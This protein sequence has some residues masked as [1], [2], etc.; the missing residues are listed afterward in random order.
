MTLL[1]SG[2]LVAAV[3]TG[4]ALL[5][6]AATVLTGGVSSTAP[7]PTIN[8]AVTTST[9][10]TTDPAS[11][12]AEGAE[13]TLTAK[14][15]PAAA[16][17]TVQFKDG[18]NPLGPP[19][20]VANGT[21]SGTTKKLTT[22]AHQL[23]AVFTP[24]NT[25]LYA[26]STSSPVAFTVTG[27]TG[28]A[29]AKDTSTALTTSPPSSAAQGTAVTLNATVAPPEAAGTVQFRDGTTPIGTPA[30][31]SNGQASTSTSTLTVGSHQLTAVF[32][33]TD[34]ATYSPSTSTVVVFQVTGSTGSTTTSIALTTSPSS[35]V[36]QGNPVTLN[37]AVT[38]TTAAGAVQFKDGT[39]DLG[40]PVTVSNGKASVST[41]TLIV[42]SHQ[43]TA[44][45]TP[46]DTTT[47]V[48]STSTVTVVITA[49]VTGA[50]TTTTLTVIL[51]FPLPQGVPVLL[52]ASVVPD[53]AVGRV[54]FQ[55]GTSALGSPVPVING[56]ATMITTSLTQGTHSLTAVFIPRK[57]AVYGPST[58]PAVSVTVTGEVGGALVEQ[59]LL[60]VQEIIQDIL[61]EDEEGDEEEKP[62]CTSDCP[63]I[64]LGKRD[65]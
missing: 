38:P 50:P 54:Q 5:T 39:T 13:V 36:A 42:G 51:D 28:A 52:K 46:T 1:L 12:A 49:A 22:G 41:S 57:P 26:Q 34:T 37:A 35:P 7:P 29:G 6:P 30:A 63:L 33:P 27:A 14:I 23:S 58:S 10:L 64:P 47:Y 17:G 40:S 2:A 3:A 4:G 62:G 59:I 53:G 24:T 21:A 9:T 18:A 55:D 25:A 44:V 19:V 8:Q 31:V 11:T 56:S 61:D 16:V 65:K 20:I 32:T 60:R 43:L 48:P 15:T 45:F